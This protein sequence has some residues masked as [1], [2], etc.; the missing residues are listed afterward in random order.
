[1]MS[2]SVYNL[3]WWIANDLLIEMSSPWWCELLIHW[4]RLIMWNDLGDGAARALYLQIE[5]NRA[6]RLLSSNWN[7][8]SKCFL[9]KLLKSLSAVNSV[10][11]LSLVKNEVW[12]RYG[13]LVSN[14]G[15]ADGSGESCNFQQ[16]S[17]IKWQSVPSTETPGISVHSSLS[18]ILEIP[19]FPKVGI[20]ARSDQYP[21]T[22]TWKVE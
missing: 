22:T 7:D 18:A 9:V 17:A 2:W 16:R 10:E 3:S 4:N 1:M 12:N 20:Y 19:Y 6:L 13:S 15:W 5:M 11:S 8:L 21:V 14:D